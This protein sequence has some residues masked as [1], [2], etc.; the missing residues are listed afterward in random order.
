M[1]LAN[2]ANTE[3]ILKDCEV[4]GGDCISHEIGATDDREDGGGMWPSC[5]CWMSGTRKENK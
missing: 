3:S 5:G 2:V 4:V 1:R